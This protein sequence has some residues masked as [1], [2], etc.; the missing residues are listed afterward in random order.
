M[1]KKMVAAEAQ[2]RREIII[3]NHKI[4]SIIVQTIAS[5]ASRQNAKFFSSNFF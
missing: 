1:N 4:N 2:G 3:A 5:P